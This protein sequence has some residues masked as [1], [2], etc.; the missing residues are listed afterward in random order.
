[1]YVAAQAIPEN[2]LFLQKCQSSRITI[3]I[4]WDAFSLFIICGPS[5]AENLPQQSVFKTKSA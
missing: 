4:V 5:L 1:M 2:E 3:I